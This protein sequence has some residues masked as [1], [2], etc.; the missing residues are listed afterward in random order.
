MEAP[1]PRATRPVPGRA[2]TDSPGPKHHLSATAAARADDA[3]GLTPPPQNRLAWWGTK[4]ASI[5]RPLGNCSPRVAR[6]PAFSLRNPLGRTLGL[7]ST[8]L[9]EPVLVLR[10]VLSLDGAGSEVYAGVNVNA[11][12]SSAGARYC[13]AGCVM[14]GKSRCF[15]FAPERQTVASGSPQ[16]ASG[17][18]TL[19]IG[20]F[21][22]WPAHCQVMLPGSRLK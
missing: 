13:Q 9:W 8:A 20:A 7:P 21:T 16:S 4:M 12:P 22:E 2:P 14:K 17:S 18:T 11:I 15:P 10:R 5:A 3:R 6:R 19:Q 1:A